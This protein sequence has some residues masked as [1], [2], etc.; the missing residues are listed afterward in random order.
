MGER[1]TG[2]AVA[3]TTSRD[4]SVIS[5]VVPHL[6]HVDMISKNLI[7]AKEKV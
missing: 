3:S 2:R 6:E 1:S 4:G 5:A 7:L